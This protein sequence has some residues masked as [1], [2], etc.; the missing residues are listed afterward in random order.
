MVKWFKTHKRK[1]IAHS[2]ILSLF[3]LYVVFLADPL[4]NRFEEGGGLS[5][6]R[7]ISLP[8]PTNNICYTIDRLGTG[9]DSIALIGWAFIGGQ[10]TD[11]SQT[12]VFL[13]SD[14]D[15]YVFDTFVVPRPNVSESFAYLNLSLDY[16]GFIAQIE[17]DFKNGTY[18]LGIYI[19]NGD[20]E[21]LQYTDRVVIISE[22]IVQ[23]VL[24]MSEPQETSLPGDLSG[25]VCFNVDYF[26]EVAGEG[27]EYIIA[28][29]G[30]AF[31]PGQ[32]PEDS[33]I[34][35]VL[36]SDASTYVF[37]TD[38]EYTPWVTSQYD[39]LDLNL[40]WSGFQARIPAE[41]IESGAYNVSI[42]IKNGDIQAL[43]QADRALT[44]SGHYMQLILLTSRPHDISLPEA[45]QN[46]FSHV[47]Y[48][49]EVVKEGK[50][51]F[52][53]VGWAFIQEQS[54]EHGEV[55][56][57]LQ[58][59]TN[60]YIFDTGPKYAPWVTLQFEY[61]DLDLDWSGFRGR[62]PTEDIENGT[63]TV[64]L[65]VEKGDIKA[66]QYTDREVSMT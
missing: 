10:S 28:I 62:I 27:N 61:L 29:Q 18:K 12:Y 21:A 16:S 54:P 30:W 35:V 45:S 13:E 4:F 42:Y 6:S 60:T 41:S 51:Y 49:Q 59:D 26:E 17:G 63:Y 31:I 47:D 39:Y 38:P 34:Y 3:V 24:L 36:K 40:D 25:N 43:Q 44:K 1:I 46:M 56:V 11:N 64:G 22:H 33:R 9:T 32:S 57:V 7:K 8:A 58:S 50:E 53:I 15:T 52:E 2:L 66:L 19:R 55:Y 14:F 48:L 20:I 37:D 5:I 65:Y 23:S